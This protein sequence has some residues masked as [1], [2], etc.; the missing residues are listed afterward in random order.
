MNSPHIPRTLHSHASPRYVVLLVYV[1]LA[2]LT[3]IVFGQVLAHDFVAYDDQTY[4]YDNPRITAGVTVHGVVAA[5]TQ[6]HARNWHPLT[7]ISHMLDCQFFGLEP[8]GHHLINVLL[9][10]ATVLL[11]FSLLHGMTAALWR[12]AFVA[13]VF[14]IHPLRTE[15]VAWLAERKD[16]LSGI[17]FM[18]TLA[19]YVHYVRRP[20]VKR[21]LCTALVFT[22]GLMSKPIL[23]TVPLLLLLLDY[24]PLNRFSR[25]RLAWRS[26]A[27]AAVF[28]K[29]PL[30]LLSAISGA[31]TLIVQKTAIDYSNQL[32]FMARVSN[33]LISYV[34][35]VR[36]M[37][38]P[39]RLAVFYPHA[40][41][42]AG[43][44]AALAL[45]VISAITAFAIA[46]RR[47][48]PYA[49]V[50]WCWYL[51]SLLPVIGLIQVGLQGHAD[52]YTYL[53]Q[54]GLVVS[55]T[56]A[57]AD[58][59]KPISKRREI[60]AGLAALII[61]LLTWRGWI[62]T[63]YWKNTQSLWSHVLAVAPDNDVANYNIAEELCAHNR[64]DE[65]I[66]H[67]EKALNALSRNSAS[68]CQLS[69]A[70]IHNAF[71]NAL[72]K[73]G[74]FDEALLH[75]RKAVELQQDCADAHSNLA[76]MLV[77]RGELS[78]AIAEYRRAL[79]I[80]PEDAAGHVRLAALLA[81]TGRDDL[82]TA[83]YRRAL[84]IAP[85]S[86]AVLNALAWTLAT[87]SH[88][89][90]RNGVEAIA[91]A[92]KANQRTAGQ[93][94]LVLRT[95]AAS[96]AE[97]RRLSDAI[98]TAERALELTDDC[99]LAELLARDIKTYRAEMYPAASGRTAEPTVAVRR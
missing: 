25:E 83:H 73:K 9:H 35:Y 48:A 45:V 94:P 60:L 79:E 82:A 91:H 52:R 42:A 16:V 70:I 27:M 21:Y 39:A 33:A 2:A 3:W 80:P 38:W 54:I 14:A 29:L 31:A 6:P 4:I 28:E 75:Y 17:F 63:S 51:V 32:P 62:Q 41:E 90:C 58:L 84:E 49:P 64:L 10:T 66:A 23:V 67:Y 43:Y 18:L 95:L 86:V 74:L 81:Q 96:Y 37:I 40:S 19:A 57:A 78:E 68:Y 26:S 7:T 13:A 22:F 87:S 99:T 47:R 72:A 15:S 59:L 71:G 97:A 30:L 53:S 61:G 88:F 12:S 34:I 1:M 65:A 77:R 11:L 93:N 85:E 36:Q 24:W 69:P 92:E 46:L 76:T 8:A 89:D 5:F 44:E 56:W 98:V 20:S 55:L 50:G